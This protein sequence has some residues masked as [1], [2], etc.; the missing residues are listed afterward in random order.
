MIKFAWWSE[1]RILF[2]RNI[3]GERQELKGLLI[4]DWM[5]DIESDTIKKLLGVKKEEI[6]VRASMIA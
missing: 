2:I 4:S 1:K 3:S 6:N 5:H